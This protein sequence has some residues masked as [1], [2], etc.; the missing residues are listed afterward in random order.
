MACKD[1]TKRSR[2]F[3][4]D[5]KRK[6][7][8]NHIEDSNIYDPGRPGAHNKTYTE[9]ERLKHFVD[10]RERR[11]PSFKMKYKSPSQSKDS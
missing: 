7:R 3:H 1:Q 4:F 10:G 11:E 6:S 8:K 5:L 2:N 9:L